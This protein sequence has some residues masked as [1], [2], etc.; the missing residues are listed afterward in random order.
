ML[1]EWARY[2]LGYS[3]F[4]HRTCNGTVIS[5]EESASETLYVLPGS[6]SDPQASSGAEREIE[7]DCNC[8]LC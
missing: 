3:L 6:Q 4:A 5:S 8:W 7:G 1:I 2:G